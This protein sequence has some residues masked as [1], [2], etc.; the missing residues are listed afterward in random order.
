MR[1]WRHAQQARSRLFSPS[2]SSRALSN[3]D[4]A[5]AHLHKALQ[6]PIR[7]PVWASYVRLVDAVGAQA[8]PVSLHRRVLRRCTPS[9]AIVRA[10][11]NAAMRLSG[12]PKRMHSYDARFKAVIQNIRATGVIPTL[13]DYHHIL[14]Q[15]SAAGNH[16]GATRVYTEILQLGL[17][18]SAKT[19]GLYLQAIARQ[20]SFPVSKRH[21]HTRATQCRRM[22]AIVLDDMQRYGVQW[23]PLNLDLAM[24]I[25]KDAF[26]VE[27]LQNLLKA[28]Y[29]IDLS[30]PDCIPLDR[31]FPH[32]LT[33]T[34]N[35]PQGAAPPIRRPLPFSTYALNT[36][37]DILGR[38]QNVSKMV[39][40]FEV[41]TCPLPGAQRHRVSS[42][43]GGEEDD[44]GVSDPGASKPSDS[45]PYTSPN[46]KT[47]NT[48]LRH[49][50]RAN[51]HVLCRHYLLQAIELNHKT[52][53]DLKNQLYRG[54]YGTILAPHFALNRR[55]FLSVWGVASRNKNR[56]LMQWVS[57]KA[58][59][60]VKKSKKNLVWFTNF[61]RGLHKRGVITSRSL[62]ES[63][64][65]EMT[66]QNA[67]AS[68]NALEN[69]E[70]EKRR[71]PFLSL[72]SLRKAAR[73]LTSAFISMP[74]ILETKIVEDTRQIIEPPRP[75]YFDLDLHIS[76]L[77]RNISQIEKFIKG[78][79]ER[80]ALSTYRIKQRHTRRVWAERDVYLRTLQS[81]AVVPKLEWASRIKSEEP[82]MTSITRLL[83]RTER[84]KKYRPKY[85]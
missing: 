46:T 11:V 84:K 60:H 1:L 25:V 79:Q 76:I 85:M 20:L 8:L 13:D 39:Q 57:A 44:F 66:P 40:T 2:Q 38:L 42:F 3:N 35:L 24:R 43:D 78:A 65:P 28:A 55:A 6:S 23:T 80:L 26:D 49:L 32:I 77:T 70:A 41:L 29:K 56:E 34:I 36:T 18:P 69:K 21:D 9:A 4:R 17:R 31:P 58:Y 63:P 83:A 64:L 71:L 68:P 62:P 59:Q 47:Y 5:L 61:Q 15:F 30:N 75:K 54:P 72:S 51:H 73:T 37:I 53:V 7:V 33:R 82:F 22:A 45:P 48:L 10:S 19:F 12:R 27:A 74:N 14:E 16:F 67:P 81:R 50:S 52:Y